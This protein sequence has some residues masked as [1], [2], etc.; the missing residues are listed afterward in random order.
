MTPAFLA[1]FII[2][3]DSGKINISTAKSIL[4]KVETTGNNPAAIVESEGLG[5]VSDDSAIRIACQEVI[6]ENPNEAASYRAGKTT[7]MGWFVVR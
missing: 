1:E 2:L 7:L 3:V 5:L 6:G 4:E